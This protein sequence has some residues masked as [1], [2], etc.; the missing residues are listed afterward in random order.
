MSIEVEL[1]EHGTLVGYPLGCEGEA[2]ADATSE[3]LFV[4][5]DATME[6]CRE[7]FSAQGLA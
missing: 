2:T 5:D 4:L 1:Y 6:S 7:I 3:A